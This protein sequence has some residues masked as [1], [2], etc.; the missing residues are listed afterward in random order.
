MSELVSPKQR[1]LQAKVIPAGEHPMTF[2]DISDN[3]LSVLRRLNAK[4]YDAYLVGG[5]IRDRLMGK[6]PKDFDIATN[7]TP[8]QIKACFKNC[9]LIGRRFR[10]AHIVFGRDIIEVAT[11][12]GHHEGESAKQV[13]EKPNKP[14]EKP[15]AISQ[16]DKK[17][18]RRERFDGIKSKTDTHGQLVRDNVFGSIDEDAERRDFT[19]NAMYYSAKDQS[20]IDFA[21]GHQAIAEKRIEMIGDN[22][23]RFREDPVRMLRAVRFSAKLD[24]HIPETM[25]K[26]IKECAHLLANIPPAR[27]FEE[28]LKLF[29]S[30]FGLHAFKLLHELGLFNLLFPQLSHLL[31]DESCREVQLIEKVLVN[32]DNRI[33]N[34]LRVTP[35]FIFAAFLWYPVEERTQQV[36]YE[37]GISEYDAFSIAVGEVMHRQ[38]QRIMIPKRF[39]IP[40]KEIWHLQKR[41]TRR[42]GRRPYVLLSHSRFRAAFDFLEIRGQIEGGDLLELSQ[43]WHEFQQVQPEQQKAML[44]ALRG[45]NNGK[46]SGAKKRKPKKKKAN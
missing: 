9:R 45:S 33:N 29:L 6:I 24:M 13:D 17:V 23:T 25:Q 32:T 38:V 11:F 19:F 20:I 18:D 40:I 22:Q 42:F 2:D 16:R 10:L 27:L 35:A 1:S 41:L 46:P 26:D 31:V 7:A 28:A 8:E 3:A 36:M 12:R 44:A 14:I 4:G 37:S 39:S 21:N 15:A 30:G 43:W 34:D 5:C